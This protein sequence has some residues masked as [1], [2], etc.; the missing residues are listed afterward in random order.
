M[1]AAKFSALQA[2]SAIMTSENFDFMIKSY[3]F[4]CL[5]GALCTCPMGG[6]STLPLDH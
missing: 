1:E 3:R 5:R 2:S 4:R 6:K